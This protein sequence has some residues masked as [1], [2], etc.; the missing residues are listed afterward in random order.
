MDEIELAQTVDPWTVV[1]LRC[2]SA[3]N[4]DA[5]EQI[6]AVAAVGGRRDG[7]IRTATSGFWLAPG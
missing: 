3:G 5:V 2:V 4:P 6:V 7:T 1:D